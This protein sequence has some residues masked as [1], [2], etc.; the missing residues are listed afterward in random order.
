[1]RQTLLEKMFA[2]EK[3]VLKQNPMK[4]NPEI[5]RRSLEAKSGNFSPCCQF[6]R[7]ILAI[8]AVPIF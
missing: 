7:Y 4:Q 6:W 8:P 3:L 1:M 2:G 5:S